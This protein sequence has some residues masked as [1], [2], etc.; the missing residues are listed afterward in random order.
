MKR[1]TTICA[2]FLGLTAGFA[3][4][5]PSIYY[6]WKNSSTGATMCEPESP[7]PQWSK[8]GGPFSDANCSIKMPE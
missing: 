4:A 6:Q 7:G 5:Q 1:I 8:T 2:L 3:S